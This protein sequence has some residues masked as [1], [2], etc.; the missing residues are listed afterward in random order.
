MWTLQEA[1]TH[2]KAW[3][4]AEMAVASAQSYTI[5]GRSLTRA[6]LPGN[7]EANPILAK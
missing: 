5:A 6:N 2:L 1:Q 4:E 7:P 3:L